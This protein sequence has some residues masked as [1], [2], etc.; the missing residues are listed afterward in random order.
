LGQGAARPA[1]DNGNHDRPLPGF[2]CGSRLQLVA[3]DLK[4]PSS[5]E[6][7]LDISPTF[8]QAQANNAP[9]FSKLPALDPVLNL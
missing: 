9:S 1:G 6:V 7:L 5:S 4:I 2:R 8:G 3:D